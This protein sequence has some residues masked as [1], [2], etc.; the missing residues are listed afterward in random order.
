MAAPLTLSV[1][2]VIIS[3]IA[4]GVNDLL[5]NFEDNGC[6]M[7]YMFEY[8]E[9]QKIDLEEAAK[10]FPSYGLHIYG[11]GNLQLDGIPVLFIPGN[12]G[13][14]KQVRSLGSVALRMAQRPRVKVHFNYFVV[15]INEDLSG[16]YGGALIKQT[17]FVHLCLKKIL[18]FYANAKHPPT[19]VVVVGHSMGGLVA[20][21]L[22]VLPDFDPMMVNTIIT[23]ATPHQKPVVALDQDLH[24]Y[25]KLVNNY[26]KSEEG[27]A[28]LQHVTV[29][30]TGGGHRD[31]QVRYA[32]TRLD[33]IVAANRA[34][35]AS[36]TAVP[37][38]WVSTDHKCSV[39]CRQMV[40]LTQRA[41]FDIVDP[42]TNQIS[43]DAD[44]RMKVFKHHFLSNNA[45]P[46]YL[47]HANDTI[48]LDPKA[49]W[50]IKDERSWTFMSRKITGSMYLAVPLDVEERSDSILVWSNLTN[51]EW[52]CYCDIPVDKKL[53]ATCTSLSAY[54]RHLPPLYSN[55]KVK[56]CMIH[57]ISLAIFCDIAVNSLSASLKIEITKDTHI[58]ISVPAGQK[59]VSI[60][61]DRYNSDER[62]LVYHLPNTWDSIISYPISATDGAA[63]LKIRNQSVFYSLHLAGLGQPITAYKAMIIPQ[64]CRKHSAENNEGSVLRL[65]VP[66]SKEETYSFSSYGK[67][68]SLPIKLQTPRPLILDW[69]WHL[70]DSVEPHLEMFLHPYCHYQLRLL[71]SAPD[72]LGQGLDWVK[73]SAEMLGLRDMAP[74]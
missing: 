54:T 14:H 20:R 15:N 2:V 25:Y 4:Y 21:G 3:I 44:L 22:F 6:E 65:N 59:Q 49:Q 52:I 58:V 74:A 43:K 57:S 70:D 61:S 27:Q 41:L 55:S 68:A 45:L 23:Q 16:L 13:S 56:K 67:V 72:S 11:E 32:L 5:T 63:M 36:T 34:V 31:I 12:S 7:T 69:D 19:S 35:S 40:L 8:P 50:E 71:A 73:V 64:G 1:S 46:N 33:E 17:K 60:T 39:W 18:T 62:H 29:V 38:S 9:Y 47:T 10:Y 51:P 66:W 48:K 28:A 53:C 30:S 24:A 37:K 26:W 42:S